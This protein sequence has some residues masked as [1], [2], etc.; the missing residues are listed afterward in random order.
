MTSPKGRLKV[1]LPPYSNLRH[2]A[3]FPLGLS[4]LPPRNQTTTPTN[5]TENFRCFS[6]SVAEIEL[7]CCTTWLW[8]RTKRNWNCQ[9]FR[10]VHH[11][12]FIPHRSGSEDTRMDKMRTGGFLIFCPNVFKKHKILRV[13]SFGFYT[14][15]KISFIIC[16]I[17]LDM[18]GFLSSWYWE[19]YTWDKTV[20][21]W[22]R[23]PFVYMDL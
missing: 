1:L 8:K 7:V 19:L 3:L 13:F 2:A 21:A 5:L 6:Q 12:K 11:A 22:N 17:G 23:P 20:I 9:R 4:L 18:I 14:F 15:I 10:W 16:V